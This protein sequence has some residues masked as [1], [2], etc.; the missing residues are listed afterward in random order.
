MEKSIPVLRTGLLR[1][2]AFRSGI[3][4]RSAVH[5]ENVKTS[6]IVVIEQCHACSHCF[7]Q[8]V[9]GRVRGEVLEV[10]AE[11]GRSIGELARQWLRLV[12]SLLSLP[13]R[14]GQEQQ[15]KKGKA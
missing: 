10:Q 4:D 1:N 2:A 13:A 3:A 14:Q 6:I 12:R 5:Q 11:R 15:Q 9:L 7:R 8:I